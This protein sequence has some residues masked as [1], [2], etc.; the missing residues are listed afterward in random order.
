MEP[1]DG[2]AG[3]ANPIEFDGFKKL[4]S[5]EF[6]VQCPQNCGL[7]GSKSTPY[8]KFNCGEFAIFGWSGGNMKTLTCPH[9]RPLPFP[10]HPLKVNGGYVDVY[11]IPEEKKGAVLKALYPF[12]PVPSL[13]AEMLDI[14]EDKTFRVRDFMVLRSPGMNWL[15]S[16]YSPSSGG[17]VIDWWDIEGECSID[18]D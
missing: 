8:E 14:H 16:P 9:E 10:T 3:K 13:D 4:A 18:L 2:A 5:T 11:V 15:V 12:V 7:K 1:Q 6:W 17:T